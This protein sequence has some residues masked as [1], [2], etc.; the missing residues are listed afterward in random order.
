M[1]IVLC[2]S[3]LPDPACWGYGPMAIRYPYSKQSSSRRKKYLGRSASARPAHSGLSS[4]RFCADHIFFPA[5]HLP[6]M[7]LDQGQTMEAAASTIGVMGIGA[8]FGR[9][10]IW[11]ADRWWTREFM[12]VFWHA[13]G[14]L[15]DVYRG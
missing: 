11:M 4:Q 7:L 5:A 12:R 9:W 6:A 13:C 14:R 10:V 15:R 3:N 2:A 1:A 8:L